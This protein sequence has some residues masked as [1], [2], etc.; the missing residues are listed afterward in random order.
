MFF[1]SLFG[2][3][4]QNNEKYMNHLTLLD[5][6]R[7]NADERGYSK[8]KQFENALLRVFRARSRPIL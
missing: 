7:K 1:D 8:R 4:L 5:R 2:R 3:R 6:T